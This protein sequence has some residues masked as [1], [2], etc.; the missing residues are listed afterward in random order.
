MDRFGHLRFELPA[1]FFIELVGLVR[2]RCGDERGSVAFSRAG[3][4]RKLADDQEIT[5]NLSHGKIHRSILIR[6]N[7]KAGDLPTQPNDVISRICGFNAEKDQ[8]T[9]A[10][11]TDDLLFHLHRGASDALDNGAHRGSVSVSCQCQCQTGIRP[12]ASW[13]LPDTDTGTDT[14]SDTDN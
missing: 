12:E 8:Q 5:R 3:K 9:P 4:Q 14:N 10:D 1:E 2:S 13:H 6:E 7:A 11:L